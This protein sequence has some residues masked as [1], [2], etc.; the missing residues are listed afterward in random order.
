MDHRTIYRA[1]YSDAIRWACRFLAK[2]NYSITDRP[3]TEVTHL[4]L[5]AP[6]FE[7]DGRI[8]GGGILEHILADLPEDITVIGGNLSHPALAGYKQVDLLWDGE[9]TAKN[10]AITADCAIR[11]AGQRMGTVF[12]GCPILVMGWGRIGKCLAQQLKAMGARVMVAARKETDLHILKALGFE[13]VDTNNLSGKLSPFRV[14]FNT[15]PAMVLD[16]LLAAQCRADCIKIEL[17]SKPGIQGED[18]VSA[19]GLPGKM[20]PESSGELIARTIVRLLGK[21]KEK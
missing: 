17:A 7:A 12:D 15:A 5:P 19:L 9:Y 13:A 3:G 21:E 20:A 14:I 18:V 1:G 16:R 4:L 8:K 2:E 6:S 10:A 11:V